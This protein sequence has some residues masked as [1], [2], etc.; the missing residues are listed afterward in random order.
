MTKFHNKKVTLDGITFDSKL[1]AELYKTL[2]ILKAAG[3]I[4][5]VECHVPFALHG[6]GGVKVATYKLDFKVLGFAHPRYIEAKGVWTSTARLKKKLFEAEYGKLEIHT[7][8][9]HWKL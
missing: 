9:D 7:Q 8:K 4:Y 3:K 1:E 2:M 5:S 6:H